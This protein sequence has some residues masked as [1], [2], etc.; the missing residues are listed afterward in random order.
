MKVIVALG[1]STCARNAS[2][3]AIDL[4]S[5]RSRMELTAV[6]VVNVV[7]P[8]GNLLKDLPGR[9]GFEPAVVSEDVGEQHDEVGRLLLADVK[10]RGAAAGVEVRT[11]LD[12]GAV[13]ERLEHHASHADMIVLGQT[14]ETE[15]RFPGQGGATANHIVAEVKGAALLVRAGGKRVRNILVGY[16]GSKA[17]AHTLAL[18]RRLGHESI[19]SVHAVYVGDVSDETCPLDGVEEHLPGFN[20]KKAV[21]Q[22]ESISGA[23]SQYG[24]QQEIDTVAIG[25]SGTSPLRDFLFGRGYENLLSNRDFNLLIT[26]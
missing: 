25:F 19:E 12:H 16:D 14:G 24:Q 1:P 21:I 20:V 13:Q 23:I 15:E 6:H 2:E 7:K 9:L 18:V 10:A 3:I 11:V 8:S 4:A 26:H 17:A 5:R 22:G